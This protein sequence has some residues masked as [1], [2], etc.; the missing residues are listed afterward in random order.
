MAI[1]SM[2]SSG[3]SIIYNI[4]LFSFITKWWHIM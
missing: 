3:C 1:M 4:T 2:S